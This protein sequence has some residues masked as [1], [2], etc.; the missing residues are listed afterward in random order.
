MWDGKS[1]KCAE[2]FEYIRK[3][4]DMS[5]K[6]F[7]FPEKLRYV[8]KNFGMSPT[9]FGENINIEPSLTEPGS[10]QTILKDA[11]TSLNE[12]KNFQRPNLYK[13]KFY[14]SLTY[15]YIYIYIYIYTV[16]SKE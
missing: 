2:T 9:I 15:I 13:S 7:V 12:I 8:R 3:I 6:I 14:G 4:N 11:S 5:G 1:T 16:N 10:H